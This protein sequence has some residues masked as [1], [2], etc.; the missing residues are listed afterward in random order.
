M[1]QMSSIVIL[2]SPVSDNQYDHLSLHTDSSSKLI[3]GR[4]KK[5]LAVCSVVS[6]NVLMYF[7]LEDIFNSLQI[8][9]DAIAL[10]VVQQFCLCALSSL[11]IT[12][13]RDCTV[14]SSKYIYWS[15]NPDY[16]K[17]YLCMHA[18]MHGFQKLF[19]PNFSN[20]MSP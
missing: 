2:L 6:D 7:C 14:S 12:S 20:S 17:N 3:M 16:V 4:K 11:I 15:L 19:V 13:V 1:L 18:C 8:Y 5:C 9:Q 10:K